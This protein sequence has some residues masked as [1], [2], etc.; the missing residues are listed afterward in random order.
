[1]TK[2]KIGASRGHKRTQQVVTTG[3]AGEVKRKF[4]KVVSETDTEI[5]FEAPAGFEFTIQKNK[6]VRYL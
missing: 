2:N 3:V 6:I 1:M 5:T 4:A